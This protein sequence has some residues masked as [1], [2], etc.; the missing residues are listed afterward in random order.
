MSWFMVKGALGLV[1]WAWI[2]IVAA[3]IGA[4]LLFAAHAYDRT[5]AAARD[6]G[7]ADTV[8]AGQQQTFEQLG[9][10]NDAQR[11][12]RAAGERSADRY[13]QCLLDSTD[14]AACE[15]YNPAPRQQ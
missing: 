12:M 5:L 15:R 4:A 9:D 11:T 8:I 10:A 13:N 3:V 7:A 14:T 2:A 1:R 6:G